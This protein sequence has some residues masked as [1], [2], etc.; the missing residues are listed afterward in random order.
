MALFGYIGEPSEG[1]LIKGCLIGDRKAQKTLYS[2]YSPRM[3]AVCMRY[4]RDRQAAEDILQD[5]FIKI[6]R[7]LS[8]FRQEGSFE[9]WMRR[10]F[11]NT[12]I[13]HY[14]RKVNLYSIVDSEDKVIDIVD[15]STFD[16]LQLQDLMD[17]VQSLSPGYRTVFN[18]YAIE[19]Y[20]HREIA[21]LLG[22]TE[23]T[24]KSQLARARQ[25]LQA[26]VIEAQKL[27]KEGGAS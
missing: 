4:A 14:R 1:D 3:F 7:N 19:G 27:P 6:F 25:L 2:R 21:E 11:V 22:V 18:L 9:G 16:H 15:E 26:K 8:K 20:N 10:I 13:E 23:G 12:S 17:M 5:G 24:S